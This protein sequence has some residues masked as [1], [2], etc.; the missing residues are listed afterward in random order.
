MTIENINWTALDNLST[1]VLWPLAILSVPTLFV[2]MS[3]A[4]SM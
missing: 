3:R 2:V 4:M 1:Y